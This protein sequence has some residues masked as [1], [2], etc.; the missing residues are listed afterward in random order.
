MVPR[1]RSQML[2]TFVSPPKDQGADV[3]FPNTVYGN[4]ESKCRSQ[5]QCSIFSWAFFRGVAVRFRKAETHTKRRS[6]R[7]RYRPWRSRCARIKRQLHDK[8]P[9]GLPHICE[10]LLFCACVRAG[11]N[12]RPILEKTCGEETPCPDLSLRFGQNTHF[13]WIFRSWKLSELTF[14]STCIV[15]RSYCRRILYRSRSMA[16]IGVP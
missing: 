12:L 14:V 3:R 16:Y 4:N 9:R 5:P 6:A 2:L 11:A 7:T 8:W 10:L 13:R 15:P 1:S